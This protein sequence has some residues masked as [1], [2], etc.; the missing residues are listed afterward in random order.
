MGSENDLKESM[1]SMCNFLIK[2]RQICNGT[3]NWTVLALRH[4]QVTFDSLLLTFS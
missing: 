3:K 1:K 2:L 4:I